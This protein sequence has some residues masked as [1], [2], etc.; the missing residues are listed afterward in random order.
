MFGLF[1]AATNQEITRYIVNSG[2][3]TVFKR[4][5][6]YIEGTNVLGIL[7]FALLIGLAASVLSSRVAIFKSF[8]KE[9]NDI[10]ILILRW[11]IL[12]AP[13]GI[14]SLIVDAIL[15]VQD[16]VESF[17]AI[18]LFAGVV[19]LTLLFYCIVE[20]GIML[21]IVKR[22]NPFRFFYYFLEPALLAFAS[23]SGAVCIHK[24][25]DVCENKVKMDL[26]IPR[27][28]IP[29]YTA[30]QSDGSAIFIA[31]SC[32]FLAGNGNETLKPGDYLTIVLLTCIL[33]TCLPSVPSSSIVAIIVVL[34][35]LNLSHLNV[36]ILYTVEWLLDRVRTTVNVYR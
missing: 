2:T 12:F 20:L 3:S 15:E 10:I 17:K 8:F 25:L 30:L 36:A 28:G 29:F 22:G 4:N 31:M 23:T 7:M 13:I 26:R 24:S 11:F 27:F 5:I 14:A 34:N 35:A 33:C 16:L 19:V 32:I 21:F 6:E 9:A 1:K 18:G